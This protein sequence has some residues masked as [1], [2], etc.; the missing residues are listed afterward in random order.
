MKKYI[1]IPQEL[2]Y[3]VNC[4]Y[5]AMSRRK[6][7]LCCT[8]HKTGT[9]LFSHILRDIAREFQLK[10][11]S[12]FQYQVN[13]DTDIWLQNHSRVNF[14]LLGRPYSGIHVIRDP[15]DVV[16]SGYFYHLRCSEA[17]CLKPKTHLQGKSYQDYLKSLSQEEGLIF[18]MTHVA[19]YTINTMAQWN[20]HNSCALEFKYEDI[21]TNYEQCFRKIFTYWG[22]G[23]PEL[24]KCLEI[25]HRHNVNRL[26][27]DELKKNSH[28]HSKE[29]CKWK[30]HFSE[31][32]LNMFQE[33]Y[34][35]IL[36]KLGYESNNF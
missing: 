6:L 29:L 30:K 36:V 5:L 2:F 7:I 17:W 4:L 32:H 21:M 14:K 31:R 33:L 13:R 25:A 12:C 19:K 22:F 1:H 27:E 15:R 23:E 26:S 28:I 24:E 9:V 11:Q 16:V 35:D 8:Y 20:Y 3:L 18:E 10:F 34:G